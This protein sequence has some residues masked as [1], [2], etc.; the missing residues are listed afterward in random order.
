MSAGAGRCPPPCPSAENRSETALFGPFLP[1]KIVIFRAEIKGSAGSRG[2]RPTATG[3]IPAFRTQK[4]TRVAPSPLELPG[5]GVRRNRVR[6]A[7]PFAH[8]S[9]PSLKSRIWRCTQRVA[10][11][12][13]KM[14]D[15][16]HV[17]QGQGVGLRPFDNHHLRAP[18]KPS[19][20]SHGSVPF[21]DM[22]GTPGHLP[23]R[24]RRSPAFPA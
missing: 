4:E 7:D 11:P 6:P 16:A 22:R 8:Q 15:T 10:S 3:R 23:C 24:S 18:V 12:V 2:R 21:S 1:Q 19:K 14:R 13:P 20:V 9:G 17:T 5:L